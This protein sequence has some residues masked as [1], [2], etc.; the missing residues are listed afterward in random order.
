MFSSLSVKVGGSMRGSL[1]RIHLWL[2]TRGI[3]L[4]HKNYP[5]SWRV[6]CILYRGCRTLW[7]SSS[8][9]PVSKS[10]P[11]WS[12]WGCIRPRARQYHHLLYI[13]YS[14]ELSLIL[15]NGNSGAQESLKPH[16]WLI[17]QVLGVNILW[18]SSRRLNFVRD[19]WWRLMNYIW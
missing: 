12:T 16:S 14:R 15:W 18:T 1:V 4:A 7:L 6:L 11:N 19:D 3:K 2:P 17:F 10:P 13:A 9:I 8:S 5:F